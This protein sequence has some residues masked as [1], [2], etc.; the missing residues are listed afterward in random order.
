MDCGGTGAHLK[1]ELEHIADPPGTI[2]GIRRLNCHRLRLAGRLGSSPFGSMKPKGLNPA[3]D[4]MRTGPKLLG[5]NF[6]AV[7]IFQKQ[8]YNPQPE[9]QRKGQGLALS[10]GPACGPLNGS[11]HRMTSCL[12]KWFLH[13]GVSPNFLRSA[14]S[15]TGS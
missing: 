11:C 13:S 7:T 10:L 2:L 8:L 4:R 9:L 12:C 5:Q 3:L 6:E 1:K 15:L 14:R